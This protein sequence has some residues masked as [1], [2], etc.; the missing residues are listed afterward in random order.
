MSSSYLEAYWS[1][2]SLVK[3]LRRLLAIGRRDSPLT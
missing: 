3:E 2:G 1:R